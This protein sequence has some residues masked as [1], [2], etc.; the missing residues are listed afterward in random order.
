MNLANWTRN[1]LLAR[2]ILLYFQHG[3]ADRGSRLAH[4]DFTVQIE[5]TTEAAHWLKTSGERIEV[6]A[7]FADVIG[8]GAFELASRTFTADEQHRVHIKDVR[9][10]PKIADVLP[11]PDY[12]THISAST[13][14]QHGDHA[15]LYCDFIQ[16]PISQLQGRT[17]TVPCD[18]LKYA[19]SHS[20][21]EPSFTGELKTKDFLAKCSVKHF[22]SEIGRA[23]V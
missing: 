20:D 22:A 8:P 18:L 21:S 13:T 1:L 2:L 23:H 9:F 3:T 6:R 5:L 14:H 15:R 12:E 17:L 11:E 16:S 7:W 19:P 4:P 10:D